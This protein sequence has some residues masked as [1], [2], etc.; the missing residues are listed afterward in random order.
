M[1]RMLG[2]IKEDIS[3]AERHIGVL[4]T[5][6]EHGPIGIIKLA[7]LLHL[8]QHRIRYSLRVLEGYGYIRASP[9]GAVITPEG[10]ALFSHLNDDLDDL[11]AILSRMKI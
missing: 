1:I 9:T 5:V 4:I 7:E 10:D 3:L 11:V 8:P 2:K 6:R